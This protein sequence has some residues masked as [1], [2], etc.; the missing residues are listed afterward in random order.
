MWDT[1]DVV[2]L[3]RLV[4]LQKAR[5]AEAHSALAKIEAALKEKRGD[6]EIDTRVFDDEWAFSARNVMST[7]GA[8]KRY[9]LS[10]SR[11]RVIA[12]EHRLWV[13]Q[14]PLG[15]GRSAKHWKLSRPRMD[16]VMGGR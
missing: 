14:M 11:I 4:V 10:K 12:K 6:A 2:T 3:E 8:A 13:A 15:F 7:G 16:L 1:L 5:V 9:G